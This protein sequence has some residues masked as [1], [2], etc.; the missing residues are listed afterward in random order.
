[1]PEFLAETHA[2]CGSPAARRA[3]AAA[4]AGE[5]SRY[6]A[7]VR[8][9][10]AIA[11]PEDETGSYLYQAPSAGAVRSAVTRAGPWPERITQAATTRSPQA[12]PGRRNE[13]R[14]SR[15]GLG[16][17]PRRDVPTAGAQPGRRQDPLPGPAAGKGVMTGLARPCYL[18]P[19][20]PSGS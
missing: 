14:N 6:P 12:R 11:V 18:P 15:P 13:H 20:L 8:L 19:S 9:L 17:R 10:L 3:G 7:P 2:P 1:M 5:P 4:P 16:A